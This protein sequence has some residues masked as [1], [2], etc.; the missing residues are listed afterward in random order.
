MSNEPNPNNGI[1]IS[2]IRPKMKDSDFKLRG[3]GML[4]A[5][6]KAIKGGL[7]TLHTLELMASNIYKFQITKEPNELNRQLIAAHILICLNDDGARNLFAAAIG[8]I[9]SVKFNG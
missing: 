5:R 6:L 1:D 7:R 9:G 3:E 8:T 2:V 4:P